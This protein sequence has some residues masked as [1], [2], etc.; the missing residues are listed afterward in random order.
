MET[1]NL[2]I[3]FTD[4]K[5]FTSLTSTQSRSQLQHLLDLQDTII[6]PVFKQ[7]GGTVV[8]T[9]GDAFLVVFDSPT[10]AVLCGIKVQENVL[11]HNATC[12][13]VDQFEVRIAINAGEVNVKEGDV[14]GE[15]VNIASRIEAIAEPN[16]V[17]FT[18]SVYLSMNKNEIPSA[19]IGHR[20]LKGIPEPVK[21]YKVLLEGTN[22][23]RAKIQRQELASKTANLEKGE[24][25]ESVPEPEPIQE[26][27]NETGY[28]EKPQTE[29][30]FQKNKKTI[31]TIIITV[32]ITII[33]IAMI[34]NGQKKKQEKELSEDL[35]FNPQKEQII[36]EPQEQIFRQPQEPEFTQPISNNNLQN[37]KLVEKI[38]ILFE[39]ENYGDI[40]A[41]LHDI[42]N[43]RF[44]QATPEE[45]ENFI[46]YVKRLSDRVPRQMPERDEFEAIIEMLR[47]KQEESIR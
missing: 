34:A 10:N 25:H 23:I 30:F 14:F 37:Q 12:P 33:V 18:E 4:M 7:F 15:A 44:K 13:S 17:Y 24:I 19:E 35:M 31:F 32:V 9:I 8:K 3:M 5:G 47:V 16:E 28:T 27:K 20:H 21:I 39:E 1:K 11:N 46:M 38:N 40:F 45:Q 2:S 42:S 22:L 36:K 26:T 29:S 41:I 43:N 6:R